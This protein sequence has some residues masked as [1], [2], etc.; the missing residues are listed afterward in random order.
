MNIVQKLPRG[1]S[2]RNTT[3]LQI[4][5]SKNFDGKLAR[6][7]KDLRI[8]LPK[9]YS[10]KQYESAFYQALSEALKIKASL[11]DIVEKGNDE[12]FS[13]NQKQL[14][15]IKDVFDNVFESKWKDTAS[16]YNSII[17]YNDV[18]RFFGADKK[19]S[20]IKFEDIEQFKKELQKYIGERNCIGTA[21]NRSINKRLSFL[22][23]LYKELQN[24]KLISPELVPTMLNLSVSETKQKPIMET[25]QQIEMQEAI[26]SN[27]DE[28]FL[29][30]FIFALHTGLRHKEIESLTI[31]NIKKKEDGFYL[32]FY[33][34]KTD[35]YTDFK[36]DTVAVQCI[37]RAKLRAL[38]RPSKKLFNITK[39][40]LR[41][42]WDRYR[43]LT[44]MDSSYVPY[45]TR[46]TFC[47]QAISMGI[48]LKTIQYV[49][50]H[51]NIQTTLTYYA[52]P[53][54]E[55]KRKVAEQMDLNFNNK[56]RA[57]EI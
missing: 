30:W 13:K 23:V 47:S 7:T 50:G 15:T 18:C 28:E 21:N 1:I 17:Y 24:R 5:A 44:S 20:K 8:S 48:D 35:C 4:T 6:K 25:R 2:L 3:T 53:T 39:G 26:K 12:S 16:E 32:D 22:R 43:S 45:T 56:R 42:K 14:A 57:N 36:L 51:K 54:A 9:N 27:N 19:M 33:R 46:H 55:M 29:D 49:M 11:T 10:A 40:S 34:T 52:K 38:S 37:N 41:H 31:N